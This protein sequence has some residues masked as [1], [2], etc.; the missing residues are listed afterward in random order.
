M[1]VRILGEGQ[2]LVDDSAADE[3]ASLDAKLEAAVEVSDEDE[4][5]TALD[6]LLARVRSI[7]TPVDPGT[8][9]ASD[10]IIPAEDATMAEVHKL[11]ADEGVI[12]S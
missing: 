7:G 1:I 9:E 11:L 2:L 10:L 4:F 5:K 8:L 6:E 12:P 3:L